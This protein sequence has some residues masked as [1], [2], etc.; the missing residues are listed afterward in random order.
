MNVIRAF[1]AR[2][3]ARLLNWA[4]D[5]LEHAGSRA[6]F[7]A[8]FDLGPDSSTVPLG[9]GIVGCGFVADFYAANLPSWPALSLRAVH[10]SNPVRANAFAARNQVPM[11]HSLEMLLSDPNIDLVVNLTNPVSHAAVTRASLLANKHVYSEKPLALDIREAEELVALARSRGLHLACAPCTV[12]GATARALQAAIARGD[13]GT[14]RLVYAELDDGPVHRMQPEN[15]ASPEGTPWPW[16]DELAMGCT[17]EHAGYHLSWLV[18]L[19]GSVEN[20]TGFSHVLAPEKGPFDFAPGPDFS[21]GCIVFS[22]GVVARL[23]CSTVAAHNHRFRVIGDEGELITDACWHDLAP[24]RLRRYDAISLR[25]ETFPIIRRHT[26]LR[27]LFGLDGSRSDLSPRVSWR[28]RISR[29][30][31]DYASGIADVARAIYE[32]GTTT[33]SG[34]SAL[35]VT[36]TMLA[37]EDAKQ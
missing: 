25:A 22:S 30:R 7:P 10:D 36:R 31:I 1:C 35:T 18:A 2:V 8:T 19:F 12:L 24:V 34:E 4:L 29:H 5:W 33:M 15:W 21:V 14:P 16:T 11:H 9:I 17:L 3:A 26:V 20:V 27:R 13:I 28:D 6:P 37:I 32:N 23:T